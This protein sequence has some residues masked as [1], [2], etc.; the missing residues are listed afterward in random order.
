M[1]LVLLNN[2]RKSSIRGKIYPLV[3]K[4]TVVKFVLSANVYLDSLPHS[5]ISFQIKYSSGTSHLS[6]FH[7][8]F[9]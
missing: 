6:L 1:K 8:I 9:I 7:K 5:K 4:T 3:N 2:G